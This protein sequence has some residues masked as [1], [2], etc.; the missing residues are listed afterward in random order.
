[1]KEIAI[2]YISMFV[3]F[4]VIFDLIHSAFAYRNHDK[5]MDAITRYNQYNFS[6]GKHECHI[7]YSEMEPYE[8]TLN[9]FWDFGC[10]NILKKEKF[11]MVKPYI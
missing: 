7:S 11:E 2:F 3:L 8:K 9:R 1:M 5:I 6:I 4:S 10:K